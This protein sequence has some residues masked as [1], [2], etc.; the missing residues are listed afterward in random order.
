MPFKFIR[1]SGAH[2]DFGACD[3]GTCTDLDVYRDSRVPTV[4]I[5][6]TTIIDQV[7]TNFVDILS[8]YHGVFVCVGNILIEHT[9]G[10]TY[11][12]NGDTVTVLYRTHAEGCVRIVLQPNSILGACP[13]EFLP[14]PN[15]RVTYHS[16][17]YAMAIPQSHKI[18]NAA[19]GSASQGSAAMSAVQGSAMQ[20]SAAMNAS[21]GLIR[22]VDAPVELVVEGARMGAYVPRTITSGASGMSGASGTNAGTNAGMLVAI[23]CVICAVFAYLKYK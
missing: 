3:L 1:I 22:Q 14:N 15:V 17:N 21:Q 4:Y 5:V 23:G 6:D 16:S 9:M 11:Q 13:A 18:A 10:Y 19:H 12:Q 7:F 20:G 8:I 2:H